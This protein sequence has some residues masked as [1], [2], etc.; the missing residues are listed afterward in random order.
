MIILTINAFCRLDRKKD[1]V[2]LQAGEYVSLGKVE[3]A[4]SRCPFVESI[5]VY[6]DSGKT[7]PVALVVPRGKEMTT[8]AKSLG[9][10]SDQLPLL[11]DN[12]AVVSSV[13]QSMEKTAKQGMC[14]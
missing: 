2:K 6:A 3:S 9:L 7:F 11:C 10:N 12:P 14:S 13:F 1:L 8:L 5:C 4:L